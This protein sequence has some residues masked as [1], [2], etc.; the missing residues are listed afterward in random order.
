MSALTE[1]QRR[2]IEENKT[3]ALEKLSQKKSQLSTKPTALQKPNAPTGFHPE[4]RSLNSASNTMPQYT[5][6]PQYSLP[7]HNPGLS[8]NKNL[9]STSG[10][11]SKTW[12]SAKT[13][14]NSY[15]KAV[16]PGA[17]PN[18]S[19]SQAVA[20]RKHDQGMT[21]QPTDSFYSKKTVLKAHAILLSR[22]R[23]MIEAGFHTGLIGLF[24]TM[25]TKEYNAM[26]KCW[27]FRLT[28]YEKL[29]KQAKSLQPDV[30]II[31]LPKIV[32]QTF[33]DAIAGRTTTSQIPKADI[34]TLDS[35][36]VETLMSFQLESV[37]LGIHRK[38]RILLA[39]DMGLGKTI[40][41]IA[42]ACYYRKDWPLLIVVP[43]SV[44]FDWAQ[45]LRRWVPSLDPQSINIVLKSKDNC[46]SGLVNILSYDIMT[47]QK[48]ELLTKRFRII[49]MDE[50]H[51]LK[52][53]KSARTNAA[54]PLLQTASRVILLSGTPAL[55]RPM[56]LY[57]QVIAVAP[58][59]ISYMDFG[60]RYC[61]GKKNPWGWDF[62]GSSNMAELQIIM[63]E[64]IM[65]RRLKKDVISQLPS[66]TR[67]MVLLNPTSIKIDKEMKHASSR[68][69]KARLKDRH[70][71]LLQYFSETASAKVRSVCDYVIDLIEA[72]HKFL[73]FAHHQEMM[74]AIED[75]IR[76]KCKVSYIRI[77]GK[78]PSEQRK[79]F[80]DKFQRQ[81]DVKIAI[82][83]ICAAN[84][85]LNLTATSMVVFAELF[86]NPGILVQA[87]DRVHRIGQLNSVNVYYLVAPG[88]A[89]DFI[90][91]LVQNKMNVLGKAGLTKDDF[92]KT[93][94][95]HFKNSKQT[96]ILKYFSE[97]FMEDVDPAEFTE[98][99]DSSNTANHTTTQIETKSD[100]PTHQPEVTSFF[101]KQDAKVV[102]KDAVIS[103]PG[104]LTTGPSKSEGDP[105]A[106]NMGWLIDDID[107]NED[108][109][110]S[111]SEPV[112]KK[113][114]D[115][116][117][118]W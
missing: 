33:S 92:T 116:D 9:S 17:K 93:D 39:D 59:I 31:P 41:A 60:V 36:L 82:L 34:T 42:L 66:K 46:T 115:D 18:S 109:D 5:S 89:D 48:K 44:R 83:S 106:D 51:F 77:D 30:L 76:N 35:C 24:K 40:Q 71:L 108:D 53:F 14:P 90:W 11:V 25:E 111:F 72:D 1:E 117:L 78:T 13:N 54:L 38:G 15:Q 64:R 28:E 20:D 118:S 22:T 58:R 107:W 105:F 114:K 110:M 21:S 103:T 6:L 95:M 97:S 32:L 45:Q 62:S 63:Q 52:N 79:F 85:G 10:Q 65:I 75:V 91:P 94:T 55:S 12:N 57:T 4:N 23:F 7:A 56:E 26:T 61:D 100:I 3:R 101:P 98:A 87:E 27:S 16:N 50:S 102:D 69:E 84:S 86:W 99:M 8:G 112:T 43:S 70:S 29:M 2:R 104:T 81:E 113:K 49:I 67:Q 80:C 73:L 74:D 47:K 37:F 96:E 88:T 68:F 19:V